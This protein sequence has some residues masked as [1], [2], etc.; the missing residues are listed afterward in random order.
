MKTFGVYSLENREQKSNWM[1]GL[2]YYFRKKTM[3]NI[4]TLSRLFAL[5]LH[6][7]LENPSG[8]FFP[9]AFLNHTR[10]NS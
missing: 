10:N 5:F 8:F 6:F 4:Y 3:V 7:N 2:E 9:D 1:T